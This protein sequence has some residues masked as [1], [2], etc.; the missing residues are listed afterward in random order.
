MAMGVVE[1]GFGN[2]YEISH[3]VEKNPPFWSRYPQSNARYVTKC[4]ARRSTR[5]GRCSLNEANR[6]QI[7]RGQYGLQALDEL[8]PSGDVI[9]VISK[10]TLGYFNCVDGANRNLSAVQDSERSTIVRIYSSAPDIGT[11]TSELSLPRL[12]NQA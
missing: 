5:F 12:L 4:G 1:H 10:R 2:F 6:Y 7:S 9:M 3:V 8:R 11:S